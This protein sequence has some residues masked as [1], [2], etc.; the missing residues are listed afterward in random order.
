M[1]M[2]DERLEKYANIGSRK[3]VAFVA[4]WLLENTTSVE[5]LKRFAKVTSGIDVAD[6]DPILWL[7]QSMG[8]LVI[9]DDAYIENHDLLCEEYRKGAAVFEEWLIDRF[10]EFALDNAIIDTNKIS[11]SIAEDAYLLAATAIKPAKHACYRNFLINYEA[12]TL[13]PDAQYRVNKA[14]DRVMKTPERQRKI[15]EKQLLANLEAQREQGERGELFVLEYELKRISDPERKS[16]IRRIS[17]IDVAAGFDIVSCNSDE[18]VRPDRFI[19]VKTYKGE[20]HFIWSDNELD[21]A[22]VMGESYF[23]YLVDDDCIGKDGYEP[24][25]IRNP[26]NVIFNSG[27]WLVEPDSYRISKLNSL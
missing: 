1:I 2:L 16:M 27:R 21:K 3:S 17:T 25:I 22:S 23:L 7:F 12:I 6:I 11:Y 24:V 10:V 26:A 4:R 13:L 18:S 8:L 15:S 14:L 9:V 20:E 5:S 19:E